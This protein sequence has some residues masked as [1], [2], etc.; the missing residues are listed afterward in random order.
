LERRDGCSKEEGGKG[1]VRGGNAGW[2][3]EKGGGGGGGR[4]EN[5]EVGGD[6]EVRI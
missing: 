6:G 5:D 1:R 2:G 4:G 3:E